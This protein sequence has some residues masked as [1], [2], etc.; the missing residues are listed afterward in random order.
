MAE[1][2]T[3]LFRKERR[4]NYLIFAGINEMAFWKR[5]KKIQTLSR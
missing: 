3:G 4:V 2:G 1:N 5:Q